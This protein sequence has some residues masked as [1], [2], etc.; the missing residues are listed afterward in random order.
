[1]SLD[2]VCG[3]PYLHRAM[4]IYSAL[5]NY[6]PSSRP[7]LALAVV[8]VTFAGL[9]Q[10]AKA[11][12]LID[13]LVLSDDDISVSGPDVTIYGTVHTNG[14]SVHPSYGNFDTSGGSTITG[15]TSAVGTI[16]ND[17]S[18]PSFLTGGTAA[19]ASPI[20][21]PTMSAVL[22]AI[23]VAPD[24]EIFGNLIYSG[25][26]TFSGIYLV[27]GFLDISSD[28][29]GTATFLVEGDIDISGNAS[30][31]NAVL[32]TSFPL[33]LALYS[34]TGHV[35]LSDATVQGSVAAKT[36]TDVSGSTSIVPEP[37]SAL[38]L[39]LGGFGAA[40]IRRRKKA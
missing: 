10:S 17:I 16:N 2:P 39:G 12:A 13:R 21:Y 34:S 40:V 19:G 8:A 33:G 22:A 31:I 18:N 5:K 27:H 25:S 15:L 26:E 20:T 37:S 14:S 35:N 36:T 7:L 30:I 24:H 6:L 11:V 1:M 28:A 9:A 32:N 29:P 23:G 3:H 38:L 4:S